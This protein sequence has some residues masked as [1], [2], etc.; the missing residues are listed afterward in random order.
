[1]EQTS[2]KW[3]KKGE[4]QK[5]TKRTTMPTCNIGRA[6]SLNIASSQHIVPPTRV[7]VGFDPVNGTLIIAENKEQGEIKVEAVNKGNSGRI[8]S[9]PLFQ[10][11]KENNI[12]PKK[13][14]GRYDPAMRA[15]IFPL[16]FQP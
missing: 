16:E 3:F 5:R 10:W 12:K 9:R 1:M 4:S 13:Y 2:I 14:E 15:L 8:V 6:L 11:L 7:N